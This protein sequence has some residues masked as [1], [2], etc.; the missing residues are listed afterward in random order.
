MLKTRKSVAKRFKIT[1]SGKVLRRTAGYAH[2]LRHKSVKR[3]RAAAADKVVSE[4][5]APHV[6]RAIPYGR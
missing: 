2:L 4:G 1:S 3:R 6:R 5:F